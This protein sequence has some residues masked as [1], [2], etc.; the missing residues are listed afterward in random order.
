MSEINTT[1]AMAGQDARDVTTLPWLENPSNPLDD[2]I[3]DSG[4]SRR[5]LRVTPDTAITLAA[6]WQ[7]VNVLSGD[8]AQL[9]LKVYQRTGEGK[10]PDRSHPTWRLLHRRPSRFHGP[11]QFKQLMMYRVLLTG[12][13]YAYILRKG[14]AV[15][16]L[17]PL[18]NDAVRVD[19]REGQPVYYWTD[20]SGSE[21]GPIGPDDM[22]HLR[23]AGNDMLCGQ[24]VV[25]IARESL[26]VGMSAQK[27]GEQY[28]ANDATPRL[29]I[30][31][32]ERTDKDAAKH[33]LKVWERR[34]SGPSNAGRPALLDSGS[35]LHVFGVSN[36]DAQF[37]ESREF[38][39]SEVAS[40]FN[41]PPHKV[42][43]LT[44]ATFSNIEQQSIDYVTNSL[45]PWL[46]RWQ[47]ECNAKLFSE[48]EI[49][50]DS[51]VAEFI[52]NAL[53]QGDFQSR[54]EGYSQ[55]IQSGWLSRNEARGF[56]NLNPINGLD[57]PLAPLNMAPAGSHGDEVDE[58]TRS[59]FVDAAST[60]IGKAYQRVMSHAAKEAAN[61]GRLSAWIHTNQSKEKELISSLVASI[62][63][64][65]KK[66]GITEKTPDQ[67]ADNIWSEVV[68]SLNEEIESE[69][70]KLKSRVNAKAA[71]CPI[72]I[73]T[74][75]KEQ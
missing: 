5:K 27:Y 48:Q 12:N 32:G 14:D 51:H 52:V 64:R 53:L 69:Q 3:E 43:D 8:V 9:P 26:S 40:W 34:H 50:T 4:N 71:D 58:D 44:R 10:Q 66:K 60:A 2:A 7:A 39:R 22:F 47:D 17:V 68:R 38:S 28:F 67:V 29:A 23:G 42:G 30:E 36:E 49:R 1:I 63:E 65:S 31:V 18:D 6:V 74:F 72:K 59:V 13:A 46:V 54:S 24:S 11:F 41:L 73:E 33:M 19:I 25:S 37:L 21:S 56:E 45:R 55:A 57:E 70:P 20:S 15:E 35:K 16:E 75:L 61:E 62:F